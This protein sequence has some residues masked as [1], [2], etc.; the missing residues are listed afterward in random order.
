MDPQVEQLLLAAE[1]DWATI[2]LAVPVRVLGFH[3]EALPMPDF[4]GAN[5]A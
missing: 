3:V 4:A 5:M 2:Q 1:D